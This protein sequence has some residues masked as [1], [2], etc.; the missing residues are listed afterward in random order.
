MNSQVRKQSER[1]LVHPKVNSRNILQHE[2]I[3]LPVKIVGCLNP[4]QLGSEGQVCD[5]TMKTLT[6]RQ[7]GRLRRIQKNGTLFRF[8]LEDGSISDVKGLAILRRPED[9]VK[10]TPGK[11]S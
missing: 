11:V 10:T 5:E 3:G 8:T 4:T 6:I 7:E 2:L 9:R 1:I